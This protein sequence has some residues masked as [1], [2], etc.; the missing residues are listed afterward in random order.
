[1]GTLTVPTSGTVSGLQNNQDINAALAALA[2]A[3]Q[4]GAAPTAATTGLA[5]MAGVLWHDTVSNLLKLRD[6][7]DANWLP[8]AFVDE[9]NK[10]IRPIIPGALFGLTLSN[11]G[12]SPNT[13]VNISSGFATDDGFAAVLSKPSGSLSIDFT[14]TGAGGLDTGSLAASTWYHCFVI[15][16]PDGTTA[17]F[18]STNLTPTLPAGYVYKRRLGSVKADASARIIAFIQDGDDFWWKVPAADASGTLSI[19]SRTLTTVSTPL[20]VNVKG[21]F[22]AELISGGGNTRVLLTDPDMP[23]TAVS[24]GAFSAVTSQTAAAIGSSNAL[25]RTNTSS[26]IGLRGDTAASFNLVTFGWVDTRRK[27]S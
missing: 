16:K 4:G 6:Q 23:D 13:K 15:G 12:V 10:V 9:T 8:F 14:T 3:N 26:Q 21:V 1:M 22:G 7:A 19:A 2:T 11:D 5:S 24:N 25:C 17:G 18:A 20:G 27:S